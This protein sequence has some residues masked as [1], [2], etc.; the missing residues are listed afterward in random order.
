MRAFCYAAL[1]KIPIIG[2]VT[3]T[4]G[5]AEVRSPTADF[6][7]TH[8]QVKLITPPLFINHFAP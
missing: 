8:K 1:R 2:D 7:Q 4:V 3:K 6:R 5:W